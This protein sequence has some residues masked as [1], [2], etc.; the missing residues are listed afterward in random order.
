MTEARRQ[1]SSSRGGGMTGSIDRA[2]EAQLA[3]LDAQVRVV[4]AIQDPERCRHDFEYYYK[5][6]FVRNDPVQF[7]WG[8][9]QHHGI[10]FLTW[11]GAN[12][13]QATRKLLVEPPGSGKSNLV[14]KGLAS[15]MVGNDPGSPTIFATSTSPLAQGR[16]LW[17]RELTQSDWFKLVFPGVRKYDKQWTVDEWTLLPPGIDRPTSDAPTFKATGTDA[18]IGGIRVKYALCDDLQNVSNSATKGERER[19]KNWFYAQ[20]LTRLAN[21]NGWLVMLANIFHGDDL[22]VELWGS[23]QFMVMHMQALYPDKDIWADVYLPKDLGDAGPAFADYC[24]VAKNDWTWQEKERKLRIIMHRRGPSLWPEAPDYAPDKLRATKSLGTGG[25]ARFEKVYNGQRVA[26]SGGIYRREWFKYYRRDKIPTTF[27]WAIM[28]WDTAA[29]TS[30]RTDWTVGG[31]I[32]AG[33]DNNLYVDELVR[34]KLEAGMGVPLMIAVWWLLALRE[35]ITVKSVMI[36]RTTYARGSIQ[37]LAR[38]WTQKDF[39]RACELYL[40]QGNSNPTLIRMIRQVLDDKESLPN[41]IK[42]AGLNP[43]KIGRTGKDAMHDDCAPYYAN[44]SIWHREDMPWLEVLESELESFPNG[45]H[46]DCAD[47]VAQA[48][49]SF[50]GVVV[51]KKSAD[52][53]NRNY[54]FL[55]LSSNLPGR[56]SAVGSSFDRRKF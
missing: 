6:I 25:P 9:H 47:V 39:V 7:P 42:I 24:E 14:A 27:K 46:D 36:E 41:V 40:E 22:T 52:E 23:G 28:S 45:G 55:D 30:D 16:S 37:Q 11:P 54:A 4:D 20:F 35:G 5:Q 26:A 1:P 2:L 33:A 50:F 56:P 48:A 12:G 34:E 15:W 10:R 29:E 8:V 38:G 18:S 19:V 21:M 44:A 3:A 43:A 49:V 32:Y 51:R 17:M 53:T 31:L 13:V